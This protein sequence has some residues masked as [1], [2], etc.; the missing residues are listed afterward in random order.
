MLLA[1]QE[2]IEQLEAEII[3]LKNLNQK[4]TIKPSKMDQQA[5]GDS[6][7]DAMIQY[8]ANVANTLDLRVD[9]ETW[10]QLDADIKKHWIG[11]PSKEK[12]AIIQSLF[13]QADQKGTRQRLSANVS[14]TQPTEDTDD[15]VVFEQTVVA[16]LDAVDLPTQLFGG[17]DD[18]PD[19]GVEPRGVASSGVHSDAADI[20]HGEGGEGSST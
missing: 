1:Q 20:G 4:P 14:D 3:R 11:I 19:D 9:S 12:A 7:S 2:R 8:D 17:Q 5:E 6:S 10:G 16:V 15:A 18:G 13:K